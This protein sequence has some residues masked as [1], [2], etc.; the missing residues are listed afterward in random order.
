M[1]QK[2]KGIKLHESYLKGWEKGL[3][4]KALVVIVKK[5]SRLNKLDRK[6]FYEQIIESYT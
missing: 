4:H 1:N 2:V 6:K 5:A 3:T